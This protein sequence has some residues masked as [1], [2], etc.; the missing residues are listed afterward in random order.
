MGKANVD[1][2]LDAALAQLAFVNGWTE[3]QCRNHARAAFD[4]WEQR[5]HMTWQLDLAWLTRHGIESIE[6]SAAE[7]DTLP[8]ITGLPVWCVSPASA[9]R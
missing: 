5:S 9:R 8:A 7:R 2:R 4:R 6:I 3:A 1:S